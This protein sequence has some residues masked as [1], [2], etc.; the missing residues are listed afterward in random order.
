[1]YQTETRFCP[2][3]SHW[4]H[5]IHIPHIH[6]W[7]FIIHGPHTHNYDSLAQLLGLHHS[8]TTYSQLLSHYP[9]T[10]L[11]SHIYYHLHKHWLPGTIFWAHIIHIPYTHTFP[12][13]PVT[14]L[15]SYMDHIHTTMTPWPSYWVM[16]RSS[17]YRFSQGHSVR[18]SWERASR[19]TINSRV[20]GKILDEHPLSH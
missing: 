11:M 5:I 7:A 15:S 9:F 16:T 17:A 19:T 14:G 6:D 12:P 18:K 3:S 4:A 13:G 20:S 8:N 1:M 10:W 2:W